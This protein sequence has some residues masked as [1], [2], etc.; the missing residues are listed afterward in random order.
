[1]G[2]VIGNSLVTSARYRVII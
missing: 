2:A 1:M